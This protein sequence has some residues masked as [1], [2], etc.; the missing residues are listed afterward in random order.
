MSLASHDF[1]IHY[2]SGLKS[3]VP[4]APSLCIEEGCREIEVHEEIPTFEADTVLDLTRSQRR[5]ATIPTLY[6]KDDDY[7][8]KELD[9]RFLLWLERETIIDIESGEAVMEIA[10]EKF[11]QAK[12]VE[13][14]CQKVIATMS[15]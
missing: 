2:K 1:T 8:D 11:S 9:A 15:N 4:Y 14:F 3:Q 7:I 5:K 10:R 13:T 6:E 12:Q